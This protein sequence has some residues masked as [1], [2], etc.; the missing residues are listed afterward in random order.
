ML[1][2]RVPQHLLIY[3]CHVI[4]DIPGRERGLHYPLKHLPYYPLYPLKFSETRK[5][6][7][8]AVPRLTANTALQYPYLTSCATHVAQSPSSPQMES[9]VVYHPGT[10]WHEDSCFYKK[11]FLPILQCL[12]GSKHFPHPFL[13]SL[14]LS[15]TSASYLTHQ[16]TAF[17]VC[18]HAFQGKLGRPTVYLCCLS[19]FPLDPEPFSKLPLKDF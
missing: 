1:C 10:A 19:D 3:D 7:G 6:K 9:V 8:Y 2:A 4:R 17:T 12:L 11:S 18:M 15:I 16:A 14:S 5:L 13:F